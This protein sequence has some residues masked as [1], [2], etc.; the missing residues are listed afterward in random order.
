MG[1][2]YFGHP[3]ACAA[4]LTNIDIIARE[5]LLDHVR[6]VGPHLQETAKSLLNLPIVGDVR[7]SHLMLGIDLVSDKHTKAPLEPCDQIPARIFK[8]CMDRGVIVRPVG[9]RIV[10][11]PPLIISTNQCDGII[12]AISASIQDVLAGR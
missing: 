11:S 4:A 12:E 6:E 2:T 7:G 5:N 1:L 9:D 8:G 3:V 10:V